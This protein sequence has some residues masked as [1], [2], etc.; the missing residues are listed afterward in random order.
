MWRL[1]RRLQAGGSCLLIERNEVN[2]AC[3]IKDLSDRLANRVQQ[4]SAGRRM[5]LPAV[6]EVLGGNIE[7]AMLIKHYDADPENQQRFGPARYAGSSSCTL[8]RSSTISTH[9][10]LS[11]ARQWM[12]PVRALGSLCVCAADASTMRPGHC[13]D[14]SSISG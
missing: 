2:A 3:F 8:S 14:P 13:P 12:K 9:A 6:E 5:C 4:T 10:M 7:Y 11:E 1:L